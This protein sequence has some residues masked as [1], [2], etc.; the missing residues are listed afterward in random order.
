VYDSAVTVEDQP[1]RERDHT[2]PQQPRGAAF[3]LS[4]IGSH[5]ASRF[6]ERLEPLGLAPSDVGLLRMIAANPGQSQRDLAAALDVVPSRVVALLDALDRKGLVERHR[7]PV[8]RRNHEVVLTEKAR[9]ALKE[10][11]AVSSAH[12]ADICAGLDAAQRDQLRELLTAIAEHQGL[13]PGVHPGYR[14]GSKSRRP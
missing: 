6:A 2:W 3:L 4:Q 13:T 12:D 1:G 9:E 11:R 5:A 10:V 7:S 8:D 14:T